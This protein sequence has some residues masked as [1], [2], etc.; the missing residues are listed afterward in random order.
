MN[1][2]KTTR[3]FLLLSLIGGL[4]T[5]AYILLNWGL[6]RE[7]VHI[8]E[9][10]FRAGIRIGV[11]YILLGSVAGGVVF[12]I[13]ALAYSFLR[14]AS[15]A[16]F[17][18]NLNVFFGEKITLLIGIAVLGFVS[19][20]SGQLALS[21]NAMKDPLDGQLLL[22][23]KPALLWLFSLCLLGILYL[24]YLTGRKSLLS[25]PCVLYTSLIFLF[26]FGLGFTLI[27]LGYGHTVS[28]EITGNFDLA[29]Y[30]VLGYQVFIAWIIFIVLF[31]IGDRV[32]KRVGEERWKSPQFRDLAIIAVLFL[33]AFFLWQSVPLIPHYHIDPPVPPNFEPYPDSDALFYDRSAQ[34]LLSAGKFQSYPDEKFVTRRPILALYLATI[35]KIG[36][37]GYEEIIP[38][39]TAV[40]SLLPVLVYL[41]ARSLHTRLSGVL[42]A[43][44]IILREYN[45]LLLSDTV[46]GVHSKLLMSE[47]PT[48]MGVVLVIYIF[49]LWVKKPRKRIYLTMLGGAVLGLTMLIRQESG[50][51]LPFL[52][53]GALIALRKNFRYYLQGMLFVGVSLVLVLVP[54]V[55]RNY[56]L[57]GKVFLDKPG[58]RLSMIRETLEIDRYRD[59]DTYQPNSTTVGGVNPE[60][61]SVIKPAGYLKSLAIPHT[62]HPYQNQDSKLDLMVNH[63][64]NQLVLSTVYLPSYPLL[65]D[66]DYLSKLFTGKLENVYG[67]MLYSPQSYVKSL[68]Y[69]WVGWDGSVAVH[70]LLPVVLI[71]LLVST[72]AFGVWKKHRWIAILPFMAMLGH[73]TIYAIV[74]IS[75]GRY[76]QEVDWITGMYYAIGI[77]EVTLTARDWIREKDQIIKPVQENRKLENS[78]NPGSLP[79]YMAAVVGFALLLPLFEAAHPNHY[80]DAAR[81]EKLTYLLSKSSNDI[82]RQEKKGIQTFLQNGGISVW[83]R[84]MYPQYI[85]SREPLGDFPATD[86]K[87]KEIG[88]FPR[89]RFNLIGTEMVLTLLERDLSPD[90]FPHGSDV[91]T[92]GCRDKGLFHALLVV[93][94]DQEGEVVRTYW[95]D[96]R[97]IGVEGCPLPELKRE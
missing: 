10:S 37:L 57:T 25:R 68:P 87:L 74:R 36:G 47:I 20:I 17:V 76:V 51:I 63:F 73:F 40:F 28:E 80:P 3:T 62:K 85:E 96:N 77:V 30:P 79:I 45:G 58:N 18:T 72:G 31:L 89:F 14:K 19:L 94:H 4:I 84:G 26:L 50:A 46:T 82:S 11:I 6:V 55:Y 95:R 61:P 2:N 5:S 38:I 21:A 15:F 56:Q 32:V 27:Q 86:K 91:L 33:T 44:I 64:T 22:A 29:G 12:S 97:F 70:S 81:Q 92:V 8:L 35:H 49:V 7:T 41:L 67:G 16:H 69:W 1:K 59:Q 48:Q 88:T 9:N 60:R 34:S 52:A 24:L 65:A 53:L 42:A 78:P 39:Q 23:A 71:L 66:I 54:W 75:G 90:H 43:C 83:G 93:V 13:T